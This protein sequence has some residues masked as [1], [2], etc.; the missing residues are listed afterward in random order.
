LL[1]YILLNFVSMFFDLQLCEIDV[2]HSVNNDFIIL[3]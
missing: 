2:F 3:I 1:C